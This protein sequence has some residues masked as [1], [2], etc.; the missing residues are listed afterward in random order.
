[1]IAV[2]LG[3]LFVTLA[4]VM[5]LPPA[6]PSRTTADR[7][8]DRPTTLSEGFH[9][10]YKVLEQ[11][12]PTGQTVLGV[13]SI[14][15]TSLL[16][17]ENRNGSFET[18]LFK[19][20][21]NTS[22][23]VQA[24]VPGK[25]DIYPTGVVGAGGAFFVTYVNGSTGHSF[26]QRIAVSGKVSRLAPPLG[27]SFDWSFLYGNLSAIYIAENSFILR[28]DP[29]DMA[30]TQ[31]LSG[32]IPPKVVLSAV[33]P[34]AGNLFLE[35]SAAVASGGSDPWLGYR[36]NV[37][38]VVNNI[39]SVP[40]VPKHHVGT[41]YTMLERVPYL[42]VGGGFYRFDSNGWSVLGGYLYRYDLATGAFRNET[43]LLL[44]PGFAVV[45]L[46]PWGDT[47]GMSA[48]R[49]TFSYV[50]GETGVEGGIYQMTL[51]RTGFSNVTALLPP[52]YVS[53]FTEVTSESGAWFIN[54]GDNATNLSAEIV[55]IKT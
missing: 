25:G 16:V 14:N 11:T 42:Y 44:A 43:S 9:P 17:I 52:G 32:S 1:V 15:D 10:D 28:V 30:I 8:V 36:A 39:S 41:F 46:E 21:G 3:I 34:S 20:P 31:N 5:D 13:A 40:N 6:S 19:V 22:T 37:T 53:E 26:W 48:Q 27:D 12:Y 38:G 35:G 18:D 50:A 51:N 4:L 54:G 24:V 7:T 49:Y 55:A 23:L 29:F 33:L 45:A 47:I 2:L